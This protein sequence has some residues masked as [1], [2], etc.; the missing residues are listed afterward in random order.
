MR[1]E[2]LISFYELYETRS[3]GAAVMM[4]AVEMRL[5]WLAPP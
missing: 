2:I 1:F 3:G 4:I 5:G